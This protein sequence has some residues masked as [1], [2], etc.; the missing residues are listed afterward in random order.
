MKRGLMATVF[1]ALGLSACSEGN[2]TMADCKR[3]FD[4]NQKMCEC[5]IDT[6]DVQLSD[7]DK[8][9]V[10]KAIGDATD[11]NDF[12]ARLEDGGISEDGVGA[13][14]SAGKTCSQM[15]QQS[16]SR[17][18]SGDQ[19]QASGR[20]DNRG[21]Q[22]SGA[23]APAQARPMPT[24]LEGDWAGTV[25]GGSQSFPVELTLF[26]D[27]SGQWGGTIAYPSKGCSGNLTQLH[28]MDE[29]HYKLLKL[30]EN[31]TSGQDKCTAG[32]EITINLMVSG[33]V[34]GLADFN[35]IDEQGTWLNASLSPVY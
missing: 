26:P 11:E 25:S 8:R 18:R 35:W 19:N 28:F 3:I 31:I 10:R 22:A 34:T 7:A 6:M 2:A 24:S 12:L 27:G 23:A 30:Q 4:N 5:F 9:I 14:L 32:G 15:H 1:I 29:N 17:D 13:V 16:D 33:N 20:A 21:P